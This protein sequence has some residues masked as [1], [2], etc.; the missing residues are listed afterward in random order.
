[1]LHH[2][3]DYLIMLMM[4]TKVKVVGIQPQ[5]LIDKELLKFNLIGDQLEVEKLQQNMQIMIL[6]IL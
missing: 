5:D 1:M 3:M 4:D 2:N 6:G